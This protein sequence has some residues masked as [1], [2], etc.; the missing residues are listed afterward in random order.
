MF[1]WGTGTTNNEQ[2]PRGTDDCSAINININPIV[3]TLC[4]ITSFNISFAK[5]QYANI[6]ENPIL[7]FGEV[8]N[9]EYLL[10]AGWKLGPNISNGSNWLSGTNAVTITS[11]A[12]TGG[13]IGIRP[14]NTDCGS[15]L[16]KGREVFIP[17][18]RPNPVFTISPS[19]LSFV[20]GTPQTKTFTVATTGSLSCP[21]SYIWNLGANN[22]WLYS[23]S[24]APETITTTTNSITLTSANGNVLPSSVSVTPVLNGNNLSPVVCSTSFTAFTSAAVISGISS[25]CTL[26]SSSVFTINAEAGNS[27]T[28]NTSN[29]Q[30]ASLSNPSN[31]QV[32][33]TSQSQGLFYITATITNPCGQTVVKTSNPVTVGAPMATIN[34]NHYCPSESAPCVLNVTPTNN[35]LQFTLSAPLGTYTPSNSDW[36]WEKVSGN[37]FL[38]DNGS[39]NA[40]SHI[41]NQA[42]IYLTGANPVDNPLKIRFR[43]KNNCGWGNWKN[44]Q[45]ND[46][47]T[48]PPAIP[49][50]Y[51]KVAPNPTGGYAATISLLNP[52]IIPT[53]TNPI[54]VK[55]YSIYGNLL[56]T[57]QMYNNSSGTVYI[58]SFPYNTMYINIIMDNHVESH[59]INKY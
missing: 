55:L 35:Y 19:S 44:A 46:G 10:P 16:A 56:S 9:Y 8:T 33:V 47:T 50:K 5:T 59:T 37:F 28:W 58:Y 22:G 41:G 36:Q 52:A 54:I 1:H 53:T 20:C 17:I 30:I 24:A 39:Y 23:G 45:W 51:Y 38:L 32:T 48:T 25:F 11:N 43:V 27:V 34:G 15:P 13:S 42:D 29:S 2:P 21:V 57:T 12:T 18:S 40:T 14:V 31:S 49:E 26:Q 7:C 3:A 4:Q 6:F